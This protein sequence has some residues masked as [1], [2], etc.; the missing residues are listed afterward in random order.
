MSEIFDQLTNAA[1]TLS[2]SATEAVDKVLV[3]LS[4]WSDAAE[5][6]ALAR[7]LEGLG[8]AT[9][10]RAAAVQRFID[11]LDEG[12]GVVTAMPDLLNES[13]EA[14]EAA[15]DLAVTSA[16]DDMR[17]KAEK[18]AEEIGNLTRQRIEEVE[19]QL[20]QG[21]QRL[22]EACDQL[23]SLTGE[24]L[25]RADRALDAL[26]ILADAVDGGVGNVSD[27]IGQVDAALQPIRPLLDQMEALA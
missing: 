8:A 25:G 26:G 10:I 24:F 12:V 19:T 23:D 20:T 16:A 17:A 4:T 9:E 22:D 7:A 15:I 13:V 6:D 2:T 3:A 5:A 18:A 1:A 21:E 11:T 14:F 27:L